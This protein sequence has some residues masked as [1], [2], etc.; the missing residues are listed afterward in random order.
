MRLPEDARVARL[1]PLPASLRLYRVHDGNC[2]G[3]A[4]S[5]CKGP[6]T[7]FTHLR[8]RNGQCVL[9]SY[10]ATTLN[11][12][13]Y[14]TVFRGIPDKFQSIPRQNLDDRMIS[15]LE[16][17]G[18]IE[19]VPLFTPELKRW[20]IDPADFFEPSDAAYGD[21]RTLGFRAWRDNPDA[22]GLIWTSV[23]DSGAHA[24]LLFG[25]RLN[26]RNLVVTSS[27]S[28]RTDPTALGDLETAGWRAGWT[29]TR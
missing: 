20:K 19:L 23:Q 4:F 13:A 26:P 25:D 8:D 21:C 12:A 27:R 22:H 10:A 5:P 9:T 6:E 11:G 16:T 7:R 28:V 24:I 17:A 15:I 14:E 1:H 29:I 2:A 18:K 3:N